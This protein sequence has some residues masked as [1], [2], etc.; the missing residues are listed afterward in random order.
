M[1]GYSLD[2]CVDPHCLPA[3]YS[4]VSSPPSV[5]LIMYTPCPPSTLHHHKHTLTTQGARLGASIF[6]FG[7]DE[8]RRLGKAI[9][10]GMSAGGEKGGKLSCCS[11]RPPFDAVAL[12]RLS[13]LANNVAVAIII[14]GDDPLC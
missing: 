10:N 13:M 3:E 12:D 1:C 6:P 7:P 14:D 4:Y 11:T 8:D 9:A 2:K 5:D